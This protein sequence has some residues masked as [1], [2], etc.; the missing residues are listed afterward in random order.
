MHRQH[1]HRPPEDV[2]AAVLGPGGVGAFLAA[3][4]DRARARVAVIARERSV[5]AIARDGIAVDSVRLGTFHA[6]PPAVTRLDEPLDVLFVATKATSLGEALER[7]VAEPAVVVPL[8]NG[9]DHL[10]LLRDRFGARAVAGSIRIESTLTAPGRVSQTSLFLRVDL[11]SADTAMRAALE[12]AA[13]LLRGAEVPAKILESEAQVLWGKLVRLNALALTTSATDAPLGRIRSAP[14]LR[15]ELERCV[16]EAARV[17]A[18][19]GAEVAPAEVMAELDEAHPTLGSSMQRD[20]AAGR[21]PELDAIAGS[22]L[23]AGARHG[24]DC[25]TV[26]ALAERVAARAGVPLPLRAAAGSSASP[27]G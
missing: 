6:R 23:R 25:P 15:A 2:S 13:D 22:V 21:E 7:V 24:I 17:A 12:S 20:L 10:S 14:A 5:A 1:V 11:A 16:V 4:L 19:E 27:P 18:A 8:L 9:L 3:A 26:A